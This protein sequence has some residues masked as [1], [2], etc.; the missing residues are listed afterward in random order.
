M[1][2]ISEVNA[3]YDEW[4]SKKNPPGRA[5]VESKLVPPYKIEFRAVAAQRE[6][7]T[8]FLKLWRHSNM[9]PTLS[10]NKD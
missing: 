3:I 4:V 2:D 7:P 8:G 5:C 10:I 1:S 6:K 9:I